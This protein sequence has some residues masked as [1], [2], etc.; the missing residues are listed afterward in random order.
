MSYT[1][2]S[3]NLKYDFN[4]NIEESKILCSTKQVE[5]IITDMDFF[6][7]PSNGFITFQKEI[8][9]VR[10][11]FMKI[12]GEPF[13]LQ[14]LFQN[15]FLD[16]IGPFLVVDS[17]ST[18]FNTNKFKVPYSGVNCN[19]IVEPIEIYNYPFRFQKLGS[20][21]Y[22]FEKELLVNQNINYDLADYLFYNRRG[23][24]KIFAAKLGIS[25]YIVT[26]MD[27]DIFDLAY[28]YKDQEMVYQ[29]FDLAEI[30]KPRYHN[31]LIVPLRDWFNL[32]FKQEVKKY[33]IAGSDT[34]MEFHD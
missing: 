7:T 31:F 8:S 10:K 14:K 4:K 34:V 17:F 6:F 15:P 21:M 28:Y 29:N 25:Y 11:P 24:T 27:N 5:T 12:K 33:V 23:I 3:C 1:I 2:G 26:I 19:E 30:K 22:K 16:E 32:K 20:S 13:N 9:S 18:K